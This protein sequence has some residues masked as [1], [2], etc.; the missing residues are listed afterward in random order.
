[1]TISYKNINSNQDMQRK[2][3][4]IKELKTDLRK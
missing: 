2:D 4:E 1:M 3:K